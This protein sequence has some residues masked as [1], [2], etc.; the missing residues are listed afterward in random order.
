MQPIDPIKQYSRTVCDQIR[1]KKARGL[2]AKELENHICDQRD[3]YILSGETE[4][5]AVNKAILQMGDPVSVGLE[6]DKAHRPK[7]QG[8]LFFLTGVLMLIGMLANYY[9]DASLHSQIAFNALPYLLAFSVFV[10]CYYLDFTILGR[11]SISLYFLF[12]FIATL[13]VLLGN[14][15]NGRTY[16]IAGLPFDLTYL[17][18]IFPLVYALFVYKMR[19]RGFRGVLYCGAGYLPLAGTLM[20]VPSA[21]GLVLFSLSALIILCFSIIRGWFGAGKRNYLV[22]VLLSTA[23]ACMLV[24][25]L[26]V[27]RTTLLSR[28]NTLINPYPERS[29]SGFLYCLIRDLLGHSQL[30]GRGAIPPFWENG[31]QEI[32]ANDTG[33]LLTSLT[34][35][36]GWIS[37][38]A[39]FAAIA[40]FAVAGFHQITKQK[41][42]LGSLVALAILLSFV[43]QSVSYMISNLGYGL[44]SSI[45]LPFVS[46]GGTALMINAALTGFM[47]SVFRTGDIYRDNTQ[48]LQS[49]RP[50]FSF[51][52]GKLVVDFKGGRI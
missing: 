29:E 1:W 15:V 49:P 25:L 28:I 30:I 18:L 5:E 35:S 43:L 41:S 23:I 6:L 21:G 7:P 26:L 13:A 44:I 51:K 45:S 31:V 33:F 17:S 27:Q 42:I 47:L 34:H 4:Q 16:W 10:V 37:F 20:L 2:A 19:G 40:V 14:N 12:L 50:V 8:L 9:I 3:T 24:F 46:H 38:I 52:D 32:L 39:V 48:S 11:Y 22:F 36:V